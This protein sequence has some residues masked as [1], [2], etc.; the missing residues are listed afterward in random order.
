MK[1]LSKQESKQVGGAV[2]CRCFRERGGVL[3]TSEIRANTFIKK[4]IVIDSRINCI[5]SFLV[6]TEEQCREYCYS[7]KHKR[8]FTSSSAITY[9][10]NASGIDGCK[11]EY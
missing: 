7:K 1:V 11:Q 8:K 5:G 3:E 6:D 4:I 2:L 9:E 10:F